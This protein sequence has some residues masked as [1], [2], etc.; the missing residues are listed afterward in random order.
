M[1]TEYPTDISPYGVRGMAGNAM[2]WCGDRYRVEGPSTFRGRPTCQAPLDPSDR[3]TLRGGS[4]SVAEGK[5]RTAY[6]SSAG[7]TA[8]SPLLGFRCCWSVS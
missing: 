1:V 5:C 2:D 6:R 4:W 7:M 8:R 3:V